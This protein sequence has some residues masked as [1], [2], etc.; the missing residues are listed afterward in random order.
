MEDDRRRLL[1]DLIALRESPIQLEEAL[2]RFPWDSDDAVWISETDIVRVLRLAQQ[3][4]LS[5]RDVQRWAEILEVRDDIDASESVRSIL[6][7]LANPQLR[8]VPA[9]RAIDGWIRTLRESH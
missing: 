4:K 3:G 9:E 6:F 5:I 8:D 2:R 7:E 1:T